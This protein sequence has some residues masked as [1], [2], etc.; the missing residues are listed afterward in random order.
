MLE[1]TRN[2]KWVQAFTILDSPSGPLTDLSVF[3][4]ILCQIRS[5]TATRSRKG[6]FENAVVATCE[7][8]TVESVIY[9]SLSRTATGLLQTGDYLIDVL[10]LNEGGTDESL[11]DPEPI[12]VINR[13]TSTYAGDTVPEIIPATVPDFAEEFNEA[14]ED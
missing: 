2:R 1:I 12:R 5:K 6:F 8:E 10:G 13:P 7:V 3:S 11:L 4:E 14:L 9:L